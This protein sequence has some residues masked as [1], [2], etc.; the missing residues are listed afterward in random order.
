MS[1]AEQ[2]GALFSD[3]DDFFDRLF[4]R[5]FRWNLPCGLV[6]IAGLAGC[7]LLLTVGFTLRHAI[8]RTPFRQ[9]SRIIQYGAVLEFDPDAEGAAQAFADAL[10]E[11]GLAHVLVGTGRLVFRNGERLSSAA[12]LTAE[13]GSLDGFYRLVDPKSG[14]SLPL[15]DAGALIPIR[16]STYYGLK[17]GDSFSVCGAS[18]E[19]R[20]VAVSDVFLNY[21]G[22][23]LFFTPESYEAATET[24]L[25]PNCFLIRMGNMRFEELEGRLSGM[26][27][28]RR[29]VDARADRARFDRLAAPQKLVSSLLLGLALVMTVSVLMSLYS[30]YLRRRA[31]EL[32]LMR[33][34]TVE[35][36]VYVSLVFAAAALLGIPSGLAGGHYLGETLLSAAD[37]PT[38]YFVHT[39]DPLT[40]V[41][42]AAF[43]AGCVL[44]A[45]GAALAELIGLNRKE[46]A[47]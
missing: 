39:P 31:R 30:L 46:S 45:H 43:T 15:P 16:M 7:C 11:N 4:S 9:F 18:L 19:S 21:F 41:F 36:A 32:A 8:E 10:E 1:G 6:I 42:A 40:Y 35:C 17:A 2:E 26:A 38:I 14:R 5:R 28:F 13:S 23:L 34:N 44:L 20:A 27:G 24:A 47:A 3:E 12:V 33:F 29:L 22:D 37:G 25:K